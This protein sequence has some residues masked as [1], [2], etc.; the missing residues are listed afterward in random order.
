MN[1][2]ICCSISA[3]LFSFQTA[4]LASANATEESKLQAAMAQSHEMVMRK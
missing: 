4:D 3:I 2:P 1:G